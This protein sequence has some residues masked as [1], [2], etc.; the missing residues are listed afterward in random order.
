MGVFVPGYW[1]PGVWPPGF[2]AELVPA[3]PL[4]PTFMAAVI[5]RLKAD[6]GLAALVGP[7]I[8]DF[9]APRAGQPGYRPPA[10]PFLILSPAEGIPDDDFNGPTSRYRLVQP[11]AF[12]ATAAEAVATLEAAM[13]AL[14]YRRLRADGTYATRPRLFWDG[15]VEVSCRRTG[16][17]RPLRLDE[18]GEGMRPLWMA[19]TT[20]TIRTSATPRVE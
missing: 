13:E 9:E 14:D 8:W 4:P 6:P 3:T 15:G 1:P 10:T 18:R 2:W 12:G 19:P 20:Y 7:R 16:P 17:I 11:T 5:A